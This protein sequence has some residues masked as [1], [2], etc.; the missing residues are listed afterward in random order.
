MFQ[1]GVWGDMARR[2]NIPAEDV[3][4][5]TLYVAAESFLE[6]GYTNTTLRG[7][8]QKTG[9][10]LNLI[11]RAFECKENILCALVTYVLEEQF[12]TAYRTL[13]GITD[14][15][16]LFYAAETSMQLYMAE[17]RESVRE[18]YLM[19]Y[20]MPKTMEII[21]QMITEKLERIFHAHLPTLT[22]KD[23][24]ELEIASG[25]VMRGF[26]S[27][28][29]DMYFT[30]ERKVRRFLEAVLRIYQVPETKVQEAIA[31]VQQ[32]D[33]QKVAT[34]VIDHMLAQLKSKMG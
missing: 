21:Q 31:F 2:A 27:R 20:S 5:R 1:Q 10:D 6:N 13:E 11:N 22:T 32:F 7:L 12:R 17:S 14:D 19:A 3:K 30:M 16:I 33:F 28:P 8:A 29:C 23:F 4:E 34:D 25:S 26:M 15:P 24:Y 18:L 9:L